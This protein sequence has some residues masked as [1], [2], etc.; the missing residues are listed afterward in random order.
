MS[1]T[2]GV[3]Q[4]KI[5]L[6]TVL[7]GT[8]SLL[9]FCALPTIIIDPFFHYHKPL[10]QY[11]YLL[12]NRYQ[13][14]Q[15]NGILRHFDYD[16]VIIG[17]S[18][19][20]NFKTSQ[21]DELFDAH[22]VKTCFSG[23]SY[24]ELNQNLE[25]A[26][27][28]NS[29]LKYVLRAL[30]TGYLTTDKDSM[31]YDASFYPNYLYNDFPFDDVEYF[32]NKSILLESTI[33]TIEYTADGGSTPSFDQY[34]NWMSG[35]IFGRDAVLSSLVRP[36]YISDHFSLSDA[37]K[38]VLIENIRQNVTSVAAANPNITFYIFLTP[39]S[40]CWWDTSVVRTGQLPAQI[41]SQKIAIEEMLRFDNIKLYSFFTNYDLICNLD[42]YKDAVHYSEN[43]N[44]QIL[45]WIKNDE[46][47]LTKDN[48]Q[49]YLN[50][51]TE[52]YGNYP[53]DSIYE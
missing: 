46:Y 29:Q 37:D 17:T 15:N 10:P 45:I 22:S 19:A 14:Y 2:N 50:D 35:Y 38:E 44:S 5:W 7:A 30:D 12:D 11:A 34:S 18:M 48:Y 31:R 1:N 42:N 53:Y 28:S 33:P 3:K 49:N 39:Y 9:F 23:A 6:I 41:E 52:F 36:E 47:L 8:L 20:E 25:T 16:S 24:K 40:I 13:R 43:I 21:F 51:I 4:H 32:L 26:V 27:A